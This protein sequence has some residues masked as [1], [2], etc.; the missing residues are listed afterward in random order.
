VAAVRRGGD[1]RDLGTTL[2]VASLLEGEVQRSGDR[3]RVST[4]LVDAAGGH[5]LW[6]DRYDATMA[7]VF[8]I[9]DEI[10]ESVVR[11][12]RVML[13][14]GE[15][16]L[17]PAPRTDVRAYENYLRGRQFLLQIRRKSMRYARDMFR[18]AIEIDPDYAPAH[19]ALAEAIA[20]EQTYYPD[21][22][23]DHR[24]ADLAS[25]RALALAPELAEA[26]A[27]RAAV[28]FTGGRLDEAEAAFHRAIERDP[29]LYEARYFY[30]RMLFQLGR[31]E[32]SAREYV[33]AMAARPSHDAAFFAGQAYEALGRD[34]EANRWYRTAVD[35]VVDHMELN[36]D[37]AR[38]ATIRAVALCRTGRREQ[39]LEWGRRA[40]EI[41]PD[42]AGVRYNLACLYAVAGEVDRSLD[43]LEA[44]VRVGFGNREW[45]ERDPD[46]DAVRRDPRFLA[47]LGSS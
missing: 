14:G 13:R 5:Q 27:A 32:E 15:G 3:L 18:R 33:A 42:D 17:R 19:A 46:L 30:G 12:L 7:D 26:H 24:E 22:E 45:L 34:D 40:V 39:G 25:R 16:G 36:P 35:R 6:S 31:Y 1:V 44:A 29:R 47:L 8:A 10:S 28:L 2:D 4:R 20:L 41:D 23:A 43:T 11:A 21:A 38:A 9:Q 37:D